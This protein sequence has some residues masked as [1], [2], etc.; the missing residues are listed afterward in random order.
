MDD[1]ATMLKEYSKIPRDRD[2]RVVGDKGLRCG[3]TAITIIDLF[4]SY[5]IQIRIYLDLG[6]LV[7]IGS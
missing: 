6:V 2:Y 1:P 3:V 4:L 5:P 7:L